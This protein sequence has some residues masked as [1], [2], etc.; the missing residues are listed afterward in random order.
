MEH[1]NQQL[2]ELFIIINVVWSDG[3]RSPSVYVLL[4]WVKKEGAS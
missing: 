2:T 1:I 4:L 3:M